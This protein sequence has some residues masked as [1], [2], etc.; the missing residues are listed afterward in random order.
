[1]KKFVL[2][3]NIVILMVKNEKFNTYFQETYLKDA[4]KIF[5]LSIVSLGEITSIAS[6]NKWGRQKLK[7]LSLILNGLHLV[8][9][10]NKLYVKAYAKIDTYSQGK[11]DGQPLPNG[12]TPRNMGKNDLWI[13]AVAHVLEATLVTTDK[14]FNHL[15]PTLIDLD[16]VDVQ[17]YK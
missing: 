4:L 6:Q 11:L 10:D 13:A 8:Q 16:Y 3:T 12:L 15:H 5:H 17:L 2:D 14:D 9:L 7:Q 1:M